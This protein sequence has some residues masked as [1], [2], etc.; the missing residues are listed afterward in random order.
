MKAQGRG[1]FCLHESVAVNQAT[2]NVYVT[3]KENARI[4]EFTSSGVFIRMFGEQVNETASDNHETANEN[5]CP[6][7]A[8]D[9][10]KAGVEGVA[11][12][13]FEAPIGIAIDNSCFEQGLQGSACT[14]EDP[15]NEDV[16]VIDRRA[17]RVQIF[18]SE[19]DFV[20]M[21]G[22]QVNETAHI[23]HETANENICPVKA[24]DK[25][26]IGIE[27]E[28]LGAF[29]ELGFG[30]DYIAIGSVG[31]DVT[32]YIGDKTQLQ[33]FEP[34][35]LVKAGGSLSAEIG[36]GANV[37]SVAVDPAGNLYVSGEERAGVYEITSKAVVGK[38]EELEFTV[39]EKFDATGTEIPGVAI[40]PIGPVGVT[41][42]DDKGSGSHMIL[43]SPSGTELT[44][45]SGGGLSE[46]LGGVAFEDTTDTLYVADTNHQEIHILTI[47]V[48]PA[49]TTGASSH[50]ASEETLLGEIN[51]EGIDSESSFEYGLCVE[52]EHCSGSSFPSKV[53]ATQAPTGPDPGSPDDGSG[54][55]FVPV[56]TKVSLPG[57]LKYHYRLVGTNTDGGE[58]QGAE[59]TFVVGTKPVIEG[60]ETLF[61]TSNGIEFAGI[62]NPDYSMTT[63]KFE[64]GPCIATCATS[65]YPGNTT[66]GSAGEGLG[67]V[68]VYKSVEGLNP[69]TSYHY[70]LSATNGEGAAPTATEGTFTTLAEPEG[71][72]PTEPEIPVAITNPSPSGVTA[73]MAT[74]SG[75]VNPD[76]APTTFAFEVGVY[77]GANTHFAVVASGEAGEGEEAVAESHQLS[78]LQ[79]GATYAFRISAANEVGSAVGAVVTFPTSPST[80]VFKVPPA[81]SLLSIPQIPFPK[82]E[83]PKKLTPKEKALAKCKLKK[84]RKLRVACERSV[85]KKYASKAPKSKVKT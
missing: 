80:V 45:F 3:D 82:P 35:G 44:S 14:S 41:I 50:A 56:E 49:V 78:G 18:S 58:V 32:V 54:F 85:R 23:N 9:K 47:F 19:G 62:V 67:G 72:V 38:P 76:G 46:G 79:P 65:P 69:E 2:G 57:P 12:G 26:G 52:P 5:I 75:S 71:E 22:G 81:P 36:A 1:S 53:T 63:Y 83:V 10:C 66:P 16:Y 60:Q 7:K 13:Q 28:K 48:G 34:S 20:R 27:E 29:S 68:H 84:K 17:F 42:V 24:G 59:S 43:Y 37:F 70:R 15:F 25:C 40:T 61:G 6:V 51:P 77:E 74:I 8:G 4:Q 39:V 64:Y 30:G 33:E 21:F 55:G 31:S 11:D 73:G